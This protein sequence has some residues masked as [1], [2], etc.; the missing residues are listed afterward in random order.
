MAPGAELREQVAMTAGTTGLL[1]PWHE[2]KHPGNGGSLGCPPSAPPVR[3]APRH[4]LWTQLTQTEGQ[5]GQDIMVIW[6][7]GREGEV[8]PFPT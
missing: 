5:K 6:K 8:R 4:H 7:G 2:R 3:Q 1:A